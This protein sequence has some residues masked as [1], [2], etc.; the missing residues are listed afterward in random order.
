[1]PEKYAALKYGKMLQKLSKHL[2]LLLGSTQWKGHK[3]LE[4]F[5]KFKSS[6]TPVEGVKIQDIH[7]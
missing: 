6:E 5:T 7:Q 2:K 1:M 3:V 4:W